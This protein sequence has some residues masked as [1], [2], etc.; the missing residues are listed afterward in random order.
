[1]KTT[2]HFCYMSIVISETNTSTTVSLINNTK[3]Q[4]PGQGTSYCLENQMVKT[5]IGDSFDSL[6]DFCLYS[7]PY[8]SDISKCYLRILVDSLTAKLR[9]LV[10]FDNP[11]DMTGMK[12]FWCPTMDVGDTCSSLVI[13]EKYLSQIFKL[14]I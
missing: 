10:W 11:K 14:E 9:L 2:H 8:S 13:Q 4:V 5:N 7:H 1:M 3:A 12:V 6:L